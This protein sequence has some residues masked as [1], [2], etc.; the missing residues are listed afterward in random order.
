LARTGTN[1]RGVGRSTGMGAKTATALA[2]ESGGMG[3]SW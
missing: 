3:E 1:I 2:M